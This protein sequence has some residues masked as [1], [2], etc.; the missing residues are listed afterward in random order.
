[1]ERVLFIITLSLPSMLVTFSWATRHMAVSLLLLMVCRWS[2]S[3]AP[4][5][6]SLSRRSS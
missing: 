1:M 2:V 6:P 5:I 3:A 4:F